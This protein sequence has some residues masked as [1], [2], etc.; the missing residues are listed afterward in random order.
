[1]TGRVVRRRL[2]AANKRQV[3]T[4]MELMGARTMQRMA[5]EIDARGH[6]PGRVG[7]QR[8]A[9]GRKGGS[10]TQAFKIRNEKFVTGPAG[11]YATTGV[12][13]RLDEFLKQAKI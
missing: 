11:G 10:I 6:I 1:M 9:D 5:A 8:L 12:D 13:G 3:N 7:F 4:A 2:L